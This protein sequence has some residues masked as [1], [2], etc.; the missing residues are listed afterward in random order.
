MSPARS[1]CDILSTIIVVQDT[2]SIHFLFNSYRRGYKK[3]I[4]VVH[5]M[6]Y[7]GL[8]DWDF[9]N[10]NMARLAL[11]VRE[12]E[13]RK[14]LRGSTL[15]FDL[16]SIDWDDYF[17]EYLPGIKKYVFKEKKADEKSCRR[18]TR[19]VT[20]NQRIYQCNLLRPSLY[21]YIA[22]YVTCTFY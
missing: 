11:D 10:Q 1:K 4:R 18:Y 14:S 20:N 7:F 17:V 9:G 22:D 13:C 8:N 6:S 5:M 12:A 2:K 16:N 21:F 15:E 19:L 3:L